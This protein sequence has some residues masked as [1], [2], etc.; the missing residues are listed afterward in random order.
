MRRLVLRLDGERQRLDG[1]P[2]ECRHLLGVGSLLLRP[3]PRFFEA[4]DIHPVRPVNDIEDRHHQQRRLPSDQVVRHAHHPRRGRAHQVVRK[5]PEVVAPHGPQVLFRRHGMHG[6]HKKRVAEEKGG[7]GEQNA[8]QV[9]QMPHRIGRLNG[10]G[11]AG[12]VEC[13]LHRLRANLRVIDTLHQG[14]QTSRE[15]RFSQTE[16]GDADQY[17]HEIHRNRAP[18]RWQTDLH[19]RCHQGNE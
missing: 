2:V 9:R 5:G 19:P 13:Q 12:K 16:V 4:A 1:A 11:H 6:R 10:A 15:Q 14:A 17:E 8:L 3:C 18:Y 7:G